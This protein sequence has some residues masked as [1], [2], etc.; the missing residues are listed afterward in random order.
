MKI[1]KNLLTLFCLSTLSFSNSKALNVDSFEANFT[2]TIQNIEQKEITYKGNVS[3]LKPYYAKWEYKEPII[4]EV[5]IAGKMV[6]I[7]EP[8]LEQALYT[9]L[10]ETIDIFSILKNANKID[11]FNYKADYNGQEFSIE[12]TEDNNLKKI[13][14]I[15]KLE[16]K[17]SIVFSNQKRDH[18]IS[19]EVFQFSPPEYYDIIRE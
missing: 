3:T 17:I 16:N 2:Q 7:N 1:Y 10:N 9:R 6:V 14:Y 19:K 13:F 4:K 12:F 8:E 18:E 5:Y 15:D 11:D